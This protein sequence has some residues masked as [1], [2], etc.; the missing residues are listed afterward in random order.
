M[1]DGQR[2]RRNR[3]NPAGTREPRQG[4]Q[5]VSDQPEPQSHAASEFNALSLIRKSALP[6]GLL[7]EL[8]IRHTQDLGV[9]SSLL[10]VKG[11]AF[12]VG[13]DAV[14]QDRTRELVGAGVASIDAGD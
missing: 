13:A 9:P 12:L 8:A 1:F 7:P 4:H 2:F 11:A 10:L 5:Q 6:H 3:T 14:Y